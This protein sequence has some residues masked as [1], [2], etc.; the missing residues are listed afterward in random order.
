MFWDYCCLPRTSTQL[1]STMRSKGVLETHMFM[2]RY[3]F[4]STF[5]SQRQHPNFFGLNTKYDNNRGA[6]PSWPA[7]TQ[8]PA[9][10]GYSF[11]PKSS[12]K[13]DETKPKQW[14]REAQ[15]RKRQMLTVMSQ[16]GTTAEGR[17]MLWTGFAGRI[18][19]LI[20]R[21]DKVQAKTRKPWYCPR[22]LQI[23]STH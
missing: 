13:H 21:E 16:N 7:Y 12:W 10:K 23:T 9:E 3:L 11:W 20:D 1:S 19:C 2:E 6:Q 4:R 5:P 22:G 18:I 15:Q 17:R 14:L 8:T